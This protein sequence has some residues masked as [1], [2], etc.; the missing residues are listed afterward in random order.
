MRPSSAELAAAI[1]DAAKRNHANP[2]TVLAIMMQMRRV[3]GASD[4]QVVVVLDHLVLSSPRTT[5]HAA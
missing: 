5:L 3:F 2:E 4:E 1:N